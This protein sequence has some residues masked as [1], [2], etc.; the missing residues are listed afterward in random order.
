MPVLQAYELH[1]VTHHAGHSSANTW[2]HQLGDGDC[3]LKPRRKVVRRSGAW[4]Y[5]YSG[6]EASMQRLSHNCPPDFPKPLL[7]VINHNCHMLNAHVLVNIIYTAWTVN[8]G[9]RRWP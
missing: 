4:Q 7:P 6:V 3:Y 8:Q 1:N 5:P 9:H 2:L